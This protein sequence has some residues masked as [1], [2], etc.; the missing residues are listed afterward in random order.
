MGIFF[1][2]N[3]AL[4]N[5]NISN[6]KFNASS[7]NGFLTQLHNISK[8]S[9]LKPLSFVHLERNVPPLESNQEMVLNEIL[10][11][12]RQRKCAAHLQEESDEASASLSDI[13]GE[14]R[15]VAHTFLCLPDKSS[16]NTKER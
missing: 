14:P 7:I 4:V 15:A 13:T 2:M 5:L 10:L 11:A 9:G 12:N 3:G 1:R 6:N 16:N 8:N